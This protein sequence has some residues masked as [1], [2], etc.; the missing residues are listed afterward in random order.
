M[1]QADE[2][3]ISHEVAGTWS[4]TTAR[5]MQSTDSAARGEREDSVQPTCDGTLVFRHLVDV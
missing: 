4:N 2:R 3:P 1:P 5:S